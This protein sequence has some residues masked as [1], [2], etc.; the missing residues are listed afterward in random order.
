M[1]FVFLFFFWPHGLWDLSSLT[2]DGTQVL[3]SER[4]SLNPWTAREFLKT[5]FSAQIN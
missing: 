5:K 4:T 3:G 2:R 1:V